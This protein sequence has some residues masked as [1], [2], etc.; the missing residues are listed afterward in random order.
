MTTEQKLRE[1][2]EECVA[3]Y[4]PVEDMLDAEAREMLD[5]WRAALALPFSEV[6]E[7]WRSASESLT[8]YGRWVE[9]HSEPTTLEEAAADAR[10][11][12]LFPSMHRNV[13]IE[14]HTV[15]T[16]PWAVNP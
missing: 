4:E 6:R 5:R 11:S 12:G 15:S 2:L 10:I 14:S 7:E 9:N 16:S 3:H 1:A 8:N 13:R